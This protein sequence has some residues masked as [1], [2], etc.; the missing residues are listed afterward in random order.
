MTARLNNLKEYDKFIANP[1]LKIKY[2]K[3]LDDCSSLKKFLSTKEEVHGG[4]LLTRDKIFS[5]VLEPHKNKF[6]RAD[7]VRKS[8]SRILAAI[9]DKLPKLKEDRR[10]KIV[11]EL[12]FAANACHPTWYEEA[13]AQYKAIVVGHSEIENRL[14]GY[15]QDFKEHVLREGYAKIC[16]GD[17]DWHVINHIRGTPFGKEIGLADQGVDDYASKDRYRNLNEENLR[18]LFKVYRENPDALISYVHQRINELS[19]V[20]YD[21]KMYEFLKSCVGFFWQV[22]EYYEDG[23]FTVIKQEYVALMLKK[24]GVIAY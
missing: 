8:I 9:A 24:I 21:I 3:M 13:L 10:K 23:G 22:A 15:V 17:Q 19:D 2:N 12:A 4:K 7:Y 16:T 11:N 14:L 1:E 5:Y 18:D 20:E 6:N